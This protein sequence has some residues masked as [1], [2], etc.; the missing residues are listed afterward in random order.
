MN[1]FQLIGEKV[2]LREVITDDYLGIYKNIQ[3][4]KIA[5]FVG[6]PYPYGQIE[7]KQFVKRAI[8]SN[9]QKVELHLAILEKKSGSLSGLIS[10]MFDN[11]N[12]VAEIGFWI[13]DSYRGKGFMPEACKLLI[14]YGFE[15]LN[16]KRI[17]GRAYSQNRSS[18]RVFEKLGFKMEGQMRE[19][20][21]RFGLVFDTNFYGLLKREFKG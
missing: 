9:K 10:L 1:E 8:E 4:K 14:K 3:D 16:L 2:I 13:G 6:T 15:K 20:V 19:N 21:Y 17:Y 7:A 18:C 12:P 5:L 11:K